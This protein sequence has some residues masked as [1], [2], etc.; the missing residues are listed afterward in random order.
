M[1][2]FDR[3]YAMLSPRGALRSGVRLIDRGNAK[4]GF[5]LVFHAAHTGIA[6]AEYRV[7]RCY[8]EGSGVPVSRAHGAR[9]LERAGNRGHVEAQSLLATLY[10]HGLTALENGHAG[11]TDLFGTNATTEPD[12][13][14]AEK[15]R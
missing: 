5:R 10:L 13:C 2:V 9:W 11:T 3:L 14:E 1:A 4:R 12:F 8:L 15:W 7:G 6:A